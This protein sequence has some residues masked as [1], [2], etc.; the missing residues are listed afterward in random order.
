MSILINNSKCNKCGKC[1]EKCKFNAIT[2]TEK[3]I[4]INENCVGC[5][6]CIN[7]CEFG[8]LSILNNQAIQEDFDDYHGVLIFIQI[9]DNCILPVSMELLNIGRKLSNE[10]NEKL[11][12]LVLGNSDFV[13]ILSCYKVDKIINYSS[14]FYN[15]Y[16]AESYLSAFYNTIMDVKPSIVLIGATNEGRQLA[17]HLANKCCTGLTADC[18][19][20]KIV[21]GNLL[22]IRP[23]YGGK[24]MAEIITKSTRPQFATVKSG[25]FELPKKDISYTTAIDIKNEVFLPKYTRSITSTK[26][27]QNCDIKNAD[28]I[29]CLGNAVKKKEDM[30]LF[31]KVAKVLGAEVGGTR[32]LVEKGFI[33]PNKQIGLSGNS[34]NPKLLITF[35]VSGSVQFLAGIKNCKKIIAVNTDKNSTILKIANYSI[36]HDIY[37]LA[38]DIIDKFK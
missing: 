9:V 32:A 4:S 8:A 21:N 24:I 1:I 30:E 18:T 15:N 33:S 23:A 11:Y 25:V 19:D 37:E 28:I 6:S 26:I 22:Q 35:G 29:L 7:A 14:N 36:V 20:L 13:N 34:I 3:S 5:N 27:E 38:Y 31:I 10:L 12:A 16:N 17:S 2:F